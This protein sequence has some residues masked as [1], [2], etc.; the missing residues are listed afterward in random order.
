MTAPGTAAYSIGCEEKRNLD[1]SC[2]PLRAHTLL[3]HHSLSRVPDSPRPT[4]PSDAHA[5]G[6]NHQAFASFV[7]HICGILGTSN[8]SLPE[9][10]VESAIEMLVALIRSGCCD[11]A[12][13]PK[14]AEAFVLVTRL[15]G[16]DGSSDCSSDQSILQAA[17]DAVRAFIQTAPDQVCAL[18]VGD[19]RTGLHRCVSVISY[20]LSA[21]A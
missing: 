17:A 8:Q 12:Q 15:A 19:G 2:V 11:M 6:V 21:S 18:T 14:L 9:G 3:P 4:C 16:A 5:G 7:P 1:L 10:C 13:Q 20:L